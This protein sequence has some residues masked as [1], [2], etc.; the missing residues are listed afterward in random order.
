[1]TSDRYH[2][3]VANP[4]EK[5]TPQELTEGWHFCL[6]W[7]LLLVGPGMEEQES[8]CCFPAPQEIA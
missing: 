5:L 8:C 4:A 1:M 3:L 6:D 7:D 2:K